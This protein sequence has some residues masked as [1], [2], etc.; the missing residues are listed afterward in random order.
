LDGADLQ[1]PRVSCG[2]YIALD[3]MSQVRYVGKVRRLGRDA[4]RQRIQT[5]RRAP[6]RWARWKWLWVVPIDERI[7]AFELSAIEELSIGALRPAENLR[8][9]IALPA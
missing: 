7:P 1:L 3:G 4:L 8:R 2:I 9:E 5:H 6:V